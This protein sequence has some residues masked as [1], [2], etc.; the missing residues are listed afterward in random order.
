MT[1]QDDLERLFDEAQALPADARAAFVE[2]V[3]A[4]DQELRAELL[5]L[6]EHVAPA[7]AFFE[8]LGEVVGSSASGHFIAP[9]L[10]PGDMVGRYTIL[11]HIGSGGMG[12]VYRAR[13]SR[14]NRDVALKLLP[15]HL[16]GG[17]ADEERLLGEARAAAALEHPNVCTVHEVG[18]TTGGQPFIAMACYDGET[19]QQR[20]RRGPL[21]VEEARDVAVQIARGL[22][23]A[24]ARGIVHRDVKPGNIM[25]ASDGIPRLLDFGL[26][27]AV[28]VSRTR[29]GVTPGTIAYM[30]PEQTRGDQVDV[31]TDLWSLG[32]VLYEMLTGARPFAAG[33]DRAV[34]QS[35]LHDRPEPPNRRVPTV[36]ESLS[37]IVMRL[38]E[39]RPED[40]YQS[41][42]QLLLDL[43]SVPA[44]GVARRLRL[45]FRTGRGRAA[46]TVTLIAL[47]AAASFALWRVGRSNSPVV[48]DV[49]APAIAVLPFRVYG[50][51]LDLWREG[52]MDLL[53]TGLDGAAGLRT[54]SVG[55]LL[56][57]W[58]KAGGDRG[59][60]ELS[61]KLEVARRTGARYAL[62][63]TAIVAGPQV[64]LLVDIHDL[65]GDRSL[66]QLQVE[67][68]ADSMLVLADRLGMQT[69][70]MILDRDPG[71]L[72]GINL[73][74]ITT[75]S[76]SALKAYLEG[77]ARFRR[78]DFNGATS[79]WE[80]AVASDTLF[81]L[82]YSRLGEA[83]AWD[84]SAHETRAVE[85]RAVAYRLASR[86]SPREA[87]LARAVWIRWQGRQAGVAMLEAAVR[88]Y[89][90]DA[91]LWYELGDAYFHD[92]GTAGGPEKAVRALTRASEL[93][94]TSAPFR[95]HLLD[96]AFV[97]QPDSAHIAQQVEAYERLAP[98][99]AR[100]R[101]AQLAFALTFGQGPA[102]AS[103]RQTLDSLDSPTAGMVFDHLQ[104]PRFAREREAVLPLLIPRL[105][106]ALPT[107]LNGHFYA[108][109]QIDG[110]L[111]QA[112][113]VTDDPRG[114]TT[115]WGCGVAALATFEFPV[116]S[117]FLAMKLA[118]RTTETPADDT[119]RIQCALID[120]AN[121]AQWEAHAVLLS[122]ARQQLRH[123]LTS[124]DSITA[125][126][127][128]EAVRFADAFARWRHGDATAAMR[129][130]QD[131]LANNLEDRF[132]ST[133]AEWG[134][135]RVALKLNRLDTA[136]LAFQSLWNVPLAHLQLARLYERTG[137]LAEAQSE[138]EFFASAWRNADPELQPMV[139]EARASAQRLAL[140][141]PE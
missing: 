116:P 16:D 37:Q 32:V 78:S 65:Q 95:A 67:G 81:A 104:H 40:R 109:A 84:E 88:K 69:L 21:A 101:A 138:F 123:A 60:T 112:L 108:L 1:P 82:A 86:L 121:R 94:P 98:G 72:P 57:R 96:L 76:L 129:G 103:A 115:S 124:G 48:A 79:A 33:N 80:R 73:A 64:R 35:I 12:T 139:Q 92:R 107:V 102:K 99:A 50:D 141:A 113:A 47:V 31:R 13:D 51:G 53:S 128:G 26:A 17:L 134:L 131:V 132:I 39:K 24:H 91:Q 127:W 9:G 71:E 61:S 59:V 8:R 42:S 18:E 63:G 93:Q 70:A 52:M 97:W 58:N 43:T 75:S 85:A 45:A 136:E 120:A 41:V 133:L 6:L 87:S 119:R 54:A 140:G 15:D 4:G 111:R 137:R 106:S 56:A 30:S 118:S 110:R 38:L 36:P 62:I 3:C 44:A 20:L 66:G 125:Y 74:G 130:F 28:D 49:P 117:L 77:E 34:I 29:P 89:P 46:V 2:Q 19:L 68:P 27:K 122:G 23:A 25:L 105:G 22:G 14:L 83:Y 114:R 7:E 10:S 126:R 55:A 90:D 135:G 11:E 5:S 100:T